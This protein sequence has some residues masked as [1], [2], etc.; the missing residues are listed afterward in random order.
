MKTEKKHRDFQHRKYEV[1]STIFSF[2]K[3]THYLQFICLSSHLCILFLSVG[4]T[5]LAASTN[6]TVSVR[7]VSNEIFFLLSFHMLKIKSQLCF[8]NYLCFLSGGA[9]SRRWIYAKGSNERNV[10]ETR[11]NLAKLQTSFIKKLMCCKQW[12]LG[13]N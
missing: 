5:P 4:S 6:R 11:Y 10:G 13:Y 9:L 2:L 12:Y 3:T 7:N 1:N 8:K